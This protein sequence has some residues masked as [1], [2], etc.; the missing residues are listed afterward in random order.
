M[1]IRSIAA[2]GIAAL[3]LGLVGLGAI[4]PAQA[5][6]SISTCIVNLPSYSLTDTSPGDADDHFDAVLACEDHA[7]QS[8]DQTGS[9]TLPKAVKASSAT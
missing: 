4:A 6:E 3:A 2:T 9:I 8:V 7:A 5:S 1:T